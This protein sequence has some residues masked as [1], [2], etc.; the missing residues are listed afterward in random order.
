MLRADESRSASRLLDPA[1]IRD[2]S[3][4][5]GETRKGVTPCFVLRRQDLSGGVRRDTRQDVFG[6]GQD[7]FDDCRARP[8][9]G[10][11]TYP[12]VNAW[13]LRTG[14]RVLTA[15]KYSSSSP[16]TTTDCPRA[17]PREQPRQVHLYR[18]HRKPVTRRIYS[19]F[20][21]SARSR[22]C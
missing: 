4:L 13:Y 18:C 10:V 19:S 9:R 2:H 11:P 12:D 21:Q 5:S 1:K 6:D 16:M 7:C 20:A 8:C 15:V 22:T 3:S 14:A 17:S